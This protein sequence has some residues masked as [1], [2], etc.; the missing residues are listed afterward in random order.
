M[1]L[2][3]CRIETEYSEV[4]DRVVDTKFQV[5]VLRPGVLPGS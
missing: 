4:L 1:G 5:L 2:L 3:G